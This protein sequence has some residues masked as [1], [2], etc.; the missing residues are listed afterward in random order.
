[1]TDRK[2]SQMLPTARSAAPSFDMAGQG[3][4]LHD[5]YM[6][7]QHAANTN[8]AFADAFK[9]NF[10]QRPSV[11]Q[12]RSGFAQMLFQRGMPMEQALAEAAGAY[13]GQQATVAP[14]MPAMQVGSHLPP[15]SAPSDL[16]AFGRHGDDMVAHIDASEAALLKRR[17]G[18]GTINPATGL[19]E[20][21]GESRD[22]QDTT[23]G[24]SH[25]VHSGG[26]SREPGSNRGTDMGALSNVGAGN[27]P[28]GMNAAI[29]SAPTAPWGAPIHTSPNG[30]SVAKDPQ[31]WQNLNDR[32]SAYD[33]A[34]REWNE[35][36][37]K[38]SLANLA[39]AVQPMGFSMEAP[40]FNRPATFSGGTYHLG[41]NPAGAIVGAGAMAAG[42]P[43]PLGSIAGG[44]YNGLGFHNLVLTGPDVPAGWEG[45]GMPGSVAAPG[46]SGLP[47]SGAPVGAGGGGT[48][49][50]S[51]GD[52]HLLPSIAGNPNPVTPGA[53]APTGSSLPP[54]SASAQQTQPPAW[55]P[56][57][58]PSP[59]G[60]Q[61]PA[62][63]YQR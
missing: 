63:Q 28:Y 12:Q 23:G 32:V 29:A 62:W 60:W 6:R 41:V 25:D 57:A 53:P 9:A 46:S 38:R 26:G 8:A 59:Y 31:H 58:G 4:A 14:V 19:P 48:S 47:G 21:Y 24:G 3:Q 56:I 55:M 1:M 13:P 42:I 36:A 44:I 40:D 5:D 11:E 43:G 35:S 16:A 27:Q 52:G 37:Q 20:F 18:A 30:V 15:I 49:I 7:R 61:R 51:A 17:G 33:K 2:P 22:H 45:P 39:N 34:A 10:P 50:G 54:I